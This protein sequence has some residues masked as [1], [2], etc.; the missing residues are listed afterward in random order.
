MPV[1]VDSTNEDRTYARN[2]IRLDL[3]PQLQTFN[4]QVETTLAQTAE[5]LS[6][7]VAYLEAE[8][9]RLESTCLQWHPLNSIALPCNPCPL[10]YNGD[11]CGAF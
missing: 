5:M 10:P 6:A 8:C 9:D 2:R 7:E 3:L 11:W 1:W 4:P